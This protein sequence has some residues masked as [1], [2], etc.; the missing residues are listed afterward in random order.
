LRIYTSKGSHFFLVKTSFIH[1]RL[2]IAVHSFDQRQKVIMRYT[3]AAALAL[4]TLASAAP[5]ETVVLD[6]R[7]EGV[8]P[9]KGKGGAPKGGTSSK[10]FSDN[11]CKGTVFIF[12][13]GSTEPGNVV[14]ASSLPTRNKRD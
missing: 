3:L 12:A 6:R 14:S 4:V 7:Q 8:A 11:G 1:F 5:T 9:A 10:Q 2:S 13:R